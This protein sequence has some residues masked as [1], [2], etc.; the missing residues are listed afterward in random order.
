MPQVILVDRNDNEIGSAEKLAAHQQA[1]LHRAFSVFIFYRPKNGPLELLLQ[2]R[3]PKKYHCGGL[4]TNSCCSHPEP[5]ETTLEAAKRRVHQE[6]G[7]KLELQEVGHF[8]Y[9]AEFANGLT[10]HEFD[11][12]F[13]GYLENKN[14]KIDDEEISAIKWVRLNEL[15]LIL[16]EKKLE[17]TPWFE[18]A[19]SWI[20]LDLSAKGD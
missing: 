5:G 18:E 11:H 7:L 12:V 2:Q 17:F 3:H 8:I 10:E 9:K 19:L 13:I 6:L 1:L 15:T 16:K 4:W 20:K 14:L